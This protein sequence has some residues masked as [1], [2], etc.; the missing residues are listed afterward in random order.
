MFKD[1]CRRPLDLF[2]TPHHLQ[3]QKVVM[4]VD[5]LRRIVAIFANA[6]R[7]THII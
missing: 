4:L 5:Y 3:E 2:P 1:G 6:M 7:V